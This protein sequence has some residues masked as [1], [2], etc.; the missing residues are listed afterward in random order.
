MFEYGSPFVDMGMYGGG[1][2]VELAKALTSTATDQLSTMTGGDALKVQYLDKLLRDTAFAD[3]HIRAFKLLKQEPMYSNVAEWT[4]RGEYGGPYGAVAG[5]GDNPPANTAELARRVGYAKYYRTLRGVDH[6]TS[7]IRSIVPAIAEEEQAGTR[8]LLGN[9]ERDIFFGDSDI[10]PEQ[11]DGILPIVLANGDSNCVI[12]MQGGAFESVDQV[13]DAAAVV[14][15]NGGTPTHMFIDTFS[16]GDI[17]KALATSLRF[18][19]AGPA[20]TAL[21]NAG[22]VPKTIS[23]AF[24]DMAFEPSIF[25]N[26]ERGYITR[27]VDP[28]YKAPSLTR[29]GD[30]INT[31]P[32]TPTLDSATPGGT[33]GTIPAGGYYYKV[34]AINKNGESAAT[35]GTAVT[36][37]AGEKVTLT[38]THT[39]ATTQ[40]FRIYRSAK[41]AADAADCRFLYHVA[42]S[43]GGTTTFVDDGSWVPGTTCAFIIDA[44]PF[45]PALD[46]QQLLP[47]M[48]LEFGIRRPRYEW[49]QMIYGF[50]RVTR[51]WRLV[52]IKNILSTQVRRTWN[53]LGTTFS[54]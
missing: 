6:P 23:T 20:G 28:V 4:E 44:N 15:S 12:D 16:I 52:V 42:A 19:N 51:V 25:L 17:Q 14:G 38:I 5:A 32:A 46:W 30:S 21:V 43:A 8:F 41:D 26:A 9:I 54:E 48:K 49:L 13:L 2:A 37:A 47:M 39:D 29:G 53:P 50:L 10:V 36:V 3:Q 18:T 11:F 24:G 27:K 34:A 1:N 40:G 7:I 33:G 45:D 22:V 31:P 35:A